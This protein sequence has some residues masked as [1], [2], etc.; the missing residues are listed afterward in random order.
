MRM[1]SQ[2][3]GL[4]GNTG[5]GNEPCPEQLSLPFNTACCPELPAAGYRN[6]TSLNNAG[7]NGNYWSGT[8][9]S[10][11]SNN[12]YE[13]NFNSD[14]HNVNNN[15]RYNG[16]S[17]RPVREITRSGKIPSLKPFGITKERLLS[18]LLVAYKDAR[19]HKRRKRPQM[20]FEFEM[21]H[22][23]VKLRDEIW[24]RRYRPGS[25]SCFI[26]NEPK[27]REI[28]A[29]GFR[30]RVV[31]HLYY[32]YTAPLYERMFIADS[33]SCRKKKGTHY[34]VN[35]LVH[36]IRSCSDNYLYR[37]YV[38]KC[39]IKGYF[40]NIDRSRL[41]ELCNESF[42]KMAYHYSDE[43]GKRWI[44]KI[45][46][47]LVKYLNEVIVLNNPVDDCA[48]KGRADAWNGL[49]ASKSL[50]TTRSGC[51]LPIG[52]LTSQLFSNVYMNRFDQYVKRWCG[53][54]HYGRYVDDAYIVSR[55]KKDLCRLRRVIG[56]F[57][58]RDLGLELHPDKTAVYD[59]ATGVAFLGVYVKPYR[60]YPENGTK[61]RMARKIMA[62]GN[63]TGKNIGSSVNSYLGILRHVKSFKLRKRLFGENPCLTR[64]GGFDAAML[65]FK[66]GALN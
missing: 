31:H 29:A 52:N 38:L 18:D 56:D 59:A 62:L 34:G 66:A 8:L 49:P 13:L 19:R 41:L 4:T 5:T 57:L 23:L 33:Y 28:F 20:E 46:Y 37:C 17:V 26:V 2:G 11:N 51:G 55:D 15:N 58:K 42:D 32:N 12:A 3:R 61:R 40:M 14:N 43:P 64:L 47:D 44:E 7:S 27:K 65:K 24:E 53:Q 50:F 16:Q 1:K 45:D 39:D 21:E 36:H 30:D 54:V 60:N 9:N 10:G 25:S 35:R 63:D 6:G 48:I 22:H